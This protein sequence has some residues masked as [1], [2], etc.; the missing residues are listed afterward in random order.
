MPKVFKILILALIVLTISF[1]ADQIKIAKSPLNIRTA[2]FKNNES[3][4]PISHALAA[5]SI[6]KIETKIHEELNLKKKVRVVVILKENL[7]A[8]AQKLSKEEFELKKEKIKEKQDK[9]LLALP[10]TDFKLKNK[11]K[12]INAFSGLVTKAGIKKLEN[13]PDVKMVYLDKKAYASLSESVPLINADDVWTSGY[14][15]NGETVC[16]IDTGVDYTHPDLGNPSCGISI[17]GDITEYFLGSEHPYQNNYNYTWTIT[18]PGFTNIAIYFSSIE[19][20]KGYDFLYIEDAS[21]NLLQEFGRDAGIYSDVWS[22]SIPG[23]TIKIHLV[24][25]YSIQ[26]NGFIIDQVLNGVVS[27]WTNCGQVIG[28]YDFVNEDNNPMDDGNHGTHCAGIIASQDSTNKGVAPGAKIVAAKALNSAGSGWFSDIAAAVDWC[29]SN[30]DTYDISV[31][32]MSLGDGGEYDESEVA[33]QCDPY[34]TAVA[35]NTAFNQ[36]IFVS[37]ASGNEAH[38]D[39]ISY[40]A[41]ASKAIS[42]GGVYDAN[43]GSVTWGGAPPTCRDETT[44]ADQIVCHTNRD[45]ILDLLAPGAF[46]TS[47]IPGGFDTYGGTSMAAPHVAGVAALLLEAD[48]GLTPTQLRDIL[49]DT[50]V[51]ILDSETSLTFPRIDAKAALDSLS[52]AVSISITTDGLVEFDIVALGETVDNSEDVQTISVD[53]GP[54]DLSVKTTLFSDETNNWALGAVGDNQVVWKYS[55]DGESWTEFLIA[56]DS[57]LLDGDVPQSETRNLH[58]RLT[59]PTISNSSNQ[60]GSTITIVAT[61]P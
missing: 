49:K 7:T 1:A 17:V 3:F 58:L 42:V 56:N 18:Q 23:D 35:I 5:P 55:K 2:P 57:Y 37:V 51:S 54:A 50:G 61:A 15:G 25:D 14:T 46:I 33:S 11:Y 30:K 32:S 10:K 26:K 41:C 48:S 19:L 53:S 36:G 12:T 16:V 59:M 52:P 20:E 6:P 31:I 44:T 60:Y 9:V 47:T 27:E 8:T 22:V 38:E 28:G 21:G 13:H 40:P 34:A 45:E 39:G 4:N 43:V 29:V 24:T